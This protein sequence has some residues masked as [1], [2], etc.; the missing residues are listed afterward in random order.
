MND[1]MIVE[2]KRRGFKGEVLFAFEAEE[3]S[4]SGKDGR[5]LSDKMKGEI[6]GRWPYPKCFFDSEIGRY[7]MRDT[8]TN[9]RVLAAMCQRHFGYDMRQRKF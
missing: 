3:L 5:L 7:R 4:R 6:T 9:R 8:T 2:A 1:F